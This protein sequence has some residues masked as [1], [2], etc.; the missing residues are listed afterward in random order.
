MSSVSLLPETKRKLLDRL[1]RDGVVLNGSKIPAPTRVAAE[2]AA[3]TLSQEQLLIREQIAKGIPLY[4]E[5][6]TLKFN[7]AID[8]DILEQSLAEMIRRHEIWRTTYQSIAGQFMQTIGTPPEHFDLPLVDLRRSPERQRKADVTRLALSQT[9]RSFDLCKGPLLRATLVAMSES[10]YWLVMAAH[11]SI[12]DGI[13]VY[14]IFPKEL[15]AIYQAFAAGLPSPFMELPLQFLDFAIW[16]RTYLSRAEELRQI[17]YWR[18]KLAGDIPRMRWPS[19]K[20]RPAERTFRGYIRQFMLPRSI[21]DRARE[22]SRRSD[23][24]MF[25]VLLATFYLLLHFYTE[26]TDLVV[27]TM[28]PSGRK[29][30]EVQGLL[31]YFLNPVALRVDLSDDPT[32]AELLRRTQRIVSEAI[33]HDDVPFEQLATALGGRAE[34]NR[35]PYFDVAISL[36]PCM[37]DSAGA[38]S[39]TSMDA[40]NGGAA[41]D[42]YVAFIDR[43]EGLHA[44]VQYNPDVFEFQE[45][46]YM[47]RDFESLL[48][49]TFAHPQER[50]SQ[51]KPS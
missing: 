15:F 50:V 34:P 35:N 51:L 18:Q 36:Q 30:S 26:Q 23:T 22:L 11:Q 20:S 27:G 7:K 3:V 9:S 17:T 14:E 31:G 28:S 13:S 8:R 21:A 49:L 24:T 41:F 19:R 10:E 12:I 32:F 48:A 43:Q 6:I 37:P 2:Q 29:R 33:S 4:N 45:I 46:R 5:S 25:I 44:R 38:W 16:Q 39:V 47:I 42:L 40:E 1:L